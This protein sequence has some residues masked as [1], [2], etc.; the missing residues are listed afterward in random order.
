MLGSLLEMLVLLGIMAI[1]ATLKAV[2]EKLGQKG[3]QA[4]KAT[5]GD[6]S[7][8]QDFGVDGQHGISGNTP[9]LQGPF[10]RGRCN[11]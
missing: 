11:L 6:A 1:L 8:R 7:D 5:L 9:A 4:E 10:R 2:F 3:Y